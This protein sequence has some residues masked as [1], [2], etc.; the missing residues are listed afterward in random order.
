MHSPAEDGDGGRSGVACC[1]KGFDG[2]GVLKTEDRVEFVGVGWQEVDFPK[3]AID[4]E[5]YAPYV[6]IRGGFCCD[7]EGA[8]G[9]RDA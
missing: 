9:E 2:D 4:V 8:I 6:L 3:D 7:R 1:V 5:V